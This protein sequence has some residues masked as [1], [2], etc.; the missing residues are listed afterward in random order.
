MTPQAGLPCFALVGPIVPLHQAPQA[1]QTRYALVDPNP[2]GAC[3][4]L[5]LRRFRSWPDSHPLGQPTVSP[6]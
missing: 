3:R 5:S 6:A 1:G 2:Q 4:P